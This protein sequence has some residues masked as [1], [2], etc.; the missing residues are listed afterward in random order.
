MLT[1]S[2][3]TE[4]NSIYEHFKKKKLEIG[5]SLFCFLVGPIVCNAMPIK[6][7]KITKPGQ[8]LQP[9]ITLCGKP[10]PIVTWEFDHQIYNST[11]IIDNG[12]YNYSYVGLIVTNAND[13]QGIKELKYT[14]KGYLGNTVGYA[15][16]SF[17][18]KSVKI[19]YNV[20]ISLSS[21]A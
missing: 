12:S 6:S 21:E 17:Q 1:K 2:V 18:C 15:T 11:S 7:Y 8:I 16:V 19:C 13:V 14:V 3:K 4:N 10:Q 5:L 20:Y 9:V